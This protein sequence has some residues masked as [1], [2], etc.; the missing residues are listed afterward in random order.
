MDTIPTSEA[1]DS[2]ATWGGM[3]PAVK[4]LAKKC[5][6]IPAHL[7]STLLP[8]PKISLKQ[9]ADFGLPALA[10]KVPENTDFFIHAEP[11][12]VTA[13][14]VSKL[15]FLPIPDEATIRRLVVESRAVWTAGS[16]SLCYSQINGTMSTHFP[17]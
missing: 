9:L 7:H 11:S 8:D 12:P 13:E 4:R 10:T 15:R 2:E 1:P 6:V 17:L 16:R 5:F 3:P 14:T